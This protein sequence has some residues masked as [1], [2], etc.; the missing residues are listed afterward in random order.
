MEGTC[1]E[2]DIIIQRS[3]LEK[4][5]FFDLDELPENIMD[6]CK[7]KCLDVK[8]FDGNVFFR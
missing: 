2:A 5:G 3:E 8:N 1:S 4:Y 6:C 7:Q